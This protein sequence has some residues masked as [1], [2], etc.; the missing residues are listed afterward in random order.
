MDSVDSVLHRDCCWSG[1]VLR[2]DNQG[3]EMTFS[4]IIGKLIGYVVGLSLAILAIA[5]LVAAFGLLLR[6]LGIM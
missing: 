3:G 6:L 4:K 1:I 5:A 2:L